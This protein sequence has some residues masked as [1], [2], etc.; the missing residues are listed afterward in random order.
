[1]S[2]IYANILYNIQNKPDKPDK[3]DKLKNKQNNDKLNNNKQ[4]NNKPNITP[5]CIHSYSY[6]YTGLFACNKCGH[7]VVVL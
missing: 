5:T 6:K 7:I 1:M 3:P 2:Y 4:N